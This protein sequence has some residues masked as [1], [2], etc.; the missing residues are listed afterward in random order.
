MLYVI[1]YYKL[2]PFQKERGIK[3]KNKAKTETENYSLNLFI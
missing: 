1:N 2:P 3:P